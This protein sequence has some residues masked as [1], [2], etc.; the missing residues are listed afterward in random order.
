MTFREKLSDFKD[1][2]VSV[3]SERL[4]LYRVKKRR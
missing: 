4:S 2:A 3:K 1:W